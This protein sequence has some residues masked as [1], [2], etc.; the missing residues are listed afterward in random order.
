MNSFKSFAFCLAVKAEAAANANPIT[1]EHMR[2]VL[3]RVSASDLPAAGHGVPVDKMDLLLDRG[4]TPPY[5]IPY[6]TE[7]NPDLAIAEPG[8]HGQCFFFS[9]AYD[10]DPETRDGSRKGYRTAQ[11][12]R[13]RLEAVRF[14][15]D[16]P[17]RFSDFVPGSYP[18]FLAVQELSSTSADNQLIQ[19]TALAKGW[20]IGIFHTANMLMNSYVP[21]SAHRATADGRPCLLVA[22]NGSHYQAIVSADGPLTGAA[23]RAR[24]G[25]LL[26]IDD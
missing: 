17:G 14:M 19:A 26:R 21:A 4:V 8:G 22:Y 18:Q 5:R 16:H 10:V 3:E 1:S 11:A 23:C 12:Q 7:A 24:F 13:I 6:L 20:N 15:R 2:A 25:R 9:L